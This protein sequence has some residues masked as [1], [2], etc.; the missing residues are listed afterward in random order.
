MNSHLEGY[1]KLSSLDFNQDKG[2]LALSYLLRLIGVVVF[3][4]IFLGFTRLIHPQLPVSLATYLT[5]ELPNNSVIVS[6]IL[7]AI[8]VVLVLTL[9]ELVH[10]SVFYIDQRIPPKIGWRGLSIFAAAPGYL[11]KP[12]IM[13]VNALA[14]FVVIS[15]LGIILIAVLPLGFLPWIFIPTVVNAAA[16]GGDFMAVVWLRKQPEDVM[17]EDHGDVLIAYQRKD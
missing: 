10:A 13:I 12:N 17:I 3:G 15:V 2:Q 4:L 7:I 11:S 8:S 9:H 16:A 1:T 14:P 6:Y 5:I